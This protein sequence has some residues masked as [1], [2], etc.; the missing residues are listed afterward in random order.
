[1]SRVASLSA[2]VFL[3]CTICPGCGPHGESEVQTAED[4]SSARSPEPKTFALHL[5]IQR[6]FAG[7]KAR[8]MTQ[9]IVGDHRSNKKWF[10][11]P[12]GWKGE[13]TET[14]DR[15][16]AYR[17]TWAKATAHGLSLIHAGIGTLTHDVVLRAEVRASIAK[18]RAVPYEDLKQLKFML[19]TLGINGSKRSVHGH[20]DEPDLV[21]WDL[22]DSER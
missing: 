6:L 13:H 12:A 3:A 14:A 17:Q 2:L 20:W 15:C 19:R 16:E 4:D 9:L 10:E 5:E 18:E 22:A 7:D 1:M 21:E 8:E 11:F